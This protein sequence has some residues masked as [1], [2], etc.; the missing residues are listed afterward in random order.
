[1]GSV[2]GC[3][4][5]CLLLLAGW[6]EGFYGVRVGEALAAYVLLV[7]YLL[8]EYLGEVSTQY[9]TLMKCIS[10][11]FGCMSLGFIA[12]GYGLAAPSARLSRATFLALLADLV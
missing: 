7:P 6:C 8:A 11:L 10:R 9:L 4:C 3:C 12:R 2:C 5:W 1:M